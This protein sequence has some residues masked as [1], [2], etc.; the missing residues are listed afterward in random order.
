M[1]Y[2][3]Y[4]FTDLKNKAIQFIKLFRLLSLSFVKDYVTIRKSRLFDSH[5][6]LSM[7][8]DLGAYRYFPV[9]HFIQKARQEG[10]NPNNTFN[11]Q[12]YLKIYPDVKKQN[13][14]PFVHYLRYGKR[15]NR[16]QNYNELQSKGNS[17]KS[18]IHT[19]ESKVE[20]FR[21]YQNNF[22][23]DIK[24]IAFYLPQF[25]PI[26]END[27]AWGQGF[28]EWT[29]VNRAK[30]QFEGHYQPHVPGELGFYDLR[31]IEVQ[32][33]QIMLA[34]NYGIYG[35]CF[36]YYWF[37]GKRLLEKPLD[38]FLENKHL[39]FKF[40]INWANENWTRRWDGRNQEII[41]KQEYSPQEDFKF[42]ID[43]AKYLKDRR[44]IRVNG[45]PLILIYRTEL[46]PHLKATAQKWR[47]WCSENGIGKIF[48]AC[49]HSFKKVHPDDIGFD[50]AVEF[51][52]NFFN[53]FRCNGH[54]TYDLND[55]FQGIF[56][57]YLN[58]IECSRKQTLPS[59]KRF[60]SLYPTWDNTARRMEYAT[61]H[62]NT[63]PERYG[64][65]LNDIC[66]FT[67]KNFNPEEQFVFINAW[68]E[69]AEGC[70]LEPDNKFGYAYLEATR[71]SIIKATEQNKT[72]PLNMSYSFHEHIFFKRNRILCNIFKIK[73][74]NTK[75]EFLIDYSKFLL[76]L[77]RNNIGFF[78][79]QNDTPLY[80]K[81][82]R[83]VELNQRKDIAKLY[84]LAL[85][86][87]TSN[88]FTFVLLQY[89]QSEHTTACIHS[90]Q[91]INDKR[92]RIIV[93]D[94]NSSLHHRKALLQQNKNDPYVKLIFNNKNLGFSKGCNIG[95]NYARNVLNSRF[96][97]VI[98][99]DTLIKDHQFIN[100][101]LQFFNEWAFSIMGPDIEVQK[102]RHE[103]PLNDYI[104]SIF[105]FNNLCQLRKKEK[106]IFLKT[107]YAE[108]KPFG[109]S[110]YNKD[111]II[112]PILQG[113][114]L[115][116][117]PL[118][119]LTNENAFDERS[120]LYGEEFILATKSFIEGD[121]LLYTNKLKI[122]HKEGGS[123]SQLDLS[124]KMMFGYDSS[125][126][127][128]KHCIEI[129]EQ[130]STLDNSSSL[131]IIQPQDIVKERNPMK[132]N[133]LFDLLFCQ[134]GY[135]GGS[136]YGKAVFKA[137]VTR[138]KEFENIDLW[139][140][141][142]PSLFI[143]N[144]VWDLLRIN[145]IKIL[146]ITGFQEIIHWVNSDLFCVFYA[147]A[148]VVYAAGYEYLK[149]VGT[150]LNFTCQKTRIIGTLLDIRDFEIASIG[151][152]LIPYRK[153]LQCLPEANCNDLELNQMISKEEEKARKLKD[154]YSEI[155]KSK[156]IE[157]LITISNYTYRSISTHFPDV[158]NKL[159]VFYAPMKDRPSPEPLRD[160]NIDFENITYA[161]IV[162]A[163]RM[164][165]NAV[166]VASAFDEIFSLKRNP[167]G[168]HFYAI[169]TGMNTFKELT[170]NKLRHKKR[171]ICLPYLPS[172][173]IEFLYKNMEFL[174]CASINEGFGYPPVEA[175]RYNKTSIVSDLTSFPEICGDAAIYCDPYDIPSI[176]KAIIKVADQKKSI[177]VIQKRYA[178]IT[179]KQQND[180][181]Q[182]INTILE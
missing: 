178:Y 117:S 160:F 139:V 4:F 60:R 56:Y 170:I 146:H 84:D 34:K 37:N 39:D 85:A 171:F 140:A 125:I 109:S 17:H 157:K 156:P 155:C 94:N 36:H 129:L 121:L 154:M 79:Y 134:G 26:P 61:I 14:N 42:I 46:I 161:L 120:F 53:L 49:C 25:H 2:F 126:N 91:T 147:P 119:I 74:L 89:N 64:N 144:W 181:E 8:S 92:V 137:F 136:E 148:I 38:Q 82:D 47:N 100:K 132:Q 32:Q 177:E 83:V 122:F 66:Q 1:K 164:E 7:Y 63:S 31:D 12:F 41:I 18:N 30:P 55:H 3:E 105:D 102:E 116:F 104:F 72:M 40:C 68:N 176:M 87:K 128:C 150:S 62:I 44:Y 6:Y 127:A 71:N 15:E 95:Y 80:K 57:D 168:E 51:A 22:K 151:N 35:F 59:Y 108:F 115:I 135:H 45:K 67:K 69:W 145:G 141:M 167:F 99:N 158:R 173:Q 50:A 118:F 27:K 179:N 52:P 142:N 73:S 101:T 124:E 166:S 180:L 174:V 29:N 143:D 112:N 103:N 153:S 90:I 130:T 96:I 107:K 131:F 113:A 23:T 54:M 43:A 9:L 182:L 159:K 10:R 88:I 133:I 11:T 5:Y 13:I 98:N 169:F 20:L 86:E 78:D 149:S 93:V 163:S 162:N 48:L 165:K 19:G 70:H 65:W 16:V 21:K 97:A 106:E 28:T 77:Y 138:I 75:S 175:M 24:L 114:M 111:F 110:S 152:K 172:E 58:A 33:R 123:S 81:N 76:F